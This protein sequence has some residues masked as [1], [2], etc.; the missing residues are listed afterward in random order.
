MWF[1]L[2]TG[3]AT[4]ALPIYEPFD[5]PVPSA[6]VGQTN[7]G[8]SVWRSLGAALPQPAVIVGNLAGG[9]WPAAI[10]NQLQAGFATTSGGARLPFGTVVTGGKLYYGGLLQVPNLGA[11][12]T[13]E[14]LAGLDAGTGNGAANPY[15]RLIIRPAV[16]GFQLGLSRNANLDAQTSWVSN[17]FT[18]A[19]TIV[20]VAAFEFGAT[21]N[22]DLAR[23]WINPDALTFGTTN[24][25][26][27]TAT[28]S[29]GADVAVQHASLVLAVNPRMPTSVR[30]DELRVA[31]TW[32][33]V[34]SGAGQPAPGN[35]TC[36]WEER[37]R[38]RDF[39]S[40]PWGNPSCPQPQTPRQVG[41]GP[42]VLRRADFAAV[43]PPT[44]SLLRATSLARQEIQG[45][46]CHNR[47]A[48]RTYTSGRTAIGAV[49]VVPAR[50]LMD[51]LLLTPVEAAETLGIGRCPR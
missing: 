29:A 27:A 42:A 28:N 37:P 21:R 16:G 47:A 46:T 48:D 1:C 41:D 38:R 3:R 15:S 30:F 7:S 8:G 50:H 36:P 51:K 19:D 11:L 39:V 9:S 26:A 17:T 18:T 25:P 10:G 49:P 2:L 4:A 35:W 5:F 6:L 22:D 24:E 43:R 20:W 13:S 14:I 45:P 12:V 31:T 32:A 40:C 34:T 23:L 33:E 44:A